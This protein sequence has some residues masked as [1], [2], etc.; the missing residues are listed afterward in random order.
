LG[1][2]LYGLKLLSDNIQQISSDKLKYF[3]TLLTKNK[4]TGL[5]FG[6][7]LTVLIQSSSASTVIVVGF[8]NA[9]LIRLTQCIS[10]I[11]GANIGTT[12]TAQII[13]FKASAIALPLI[14]I[15]MALL[16]FSKKAHIKTIGQL[17]VGLGLLFF[18]LKLMGD[19]LKPLK[20]YQPF[21]DVMQNMG[22]H[23]ILGVLAGT[24]V[25]IALQS[26]SATTGMI[27]TLGSLG[28]INIETAFILELGSNVGTT[29]TAQI[30]AFNANVTAKRVAWSHT[31][32][33][34]IGTAY[35]IV[36]LNVKV[37]GHAIFLHLINWVTPGDVFAGESVERAIANGHT[38]FN[39]TNAL[40]LFPFIGTI[41]KMTEKIIPEK[42][43]TIDH[44][45]KFLDK[46]MSTS[47]AI[48]ISQASLET[49]RLA[50]L[51]KE[52]TKIVY[53]VISNNK[54][55]PTITENQNGISA[56]KTQIVEFL[57]EMTPDLDH[58]QWAKRSNN[59]IHISEH[60]N[61]ITDYNVELMSQFTK[62]KSTKDYP[63]E[64]MVEIKDLHKLIQ[65]MMF[66]T[67]SQ[68]DQFST[69][70]DRFN[71][72]DKDA[73]Y[74]IHTLSRNNV[75][76]IREKEISPRTG[77]YVGEM[78]NNLDHIRDQIVK[79][80]DYIKEL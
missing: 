14:A 80:A 25:T 42:T 36:L 7:I 57:I 48:A 74:L 58:P 50:N 17:I 49:K 70:A 10:V 6:A 20:E 3:L 53:K 21:L 34:V 54:P 33:N 31:L 16:L 78:V 43:G 27:V 26:S 72:L 65:E 8:A 23:P 28:L 44:T 59:L 66:V 35:M 39:V 32:F 60:L 12:I 68:F 69:V 61:R 76:K 18:G 67:S 1:V 79:M 22:H 47:P 51:T 52:T 19:F 38:L 13:A 37:G 55:I 9:G 46:R 56:L 30:A 24:L 40:I 64:L 63:K 2:F 29:V 4:L 41:A 15:G 77:F 71:A 75:Q 11:F 45:I 73:T 5:L 62:I